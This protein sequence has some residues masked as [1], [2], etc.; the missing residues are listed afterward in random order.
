MLAIEPLVEAGV[1]WSATVEVQL[2]AQAAAVKAEPAV[3]VACAARAAMGHSFPGAKITD[4]FIF[5]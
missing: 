2:E 5:G 4:L 3:L 1:V